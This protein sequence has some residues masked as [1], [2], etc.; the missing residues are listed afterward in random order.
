MKKKIA[1][2]MAA[3]MTFA[4]MATMNVFGAA[5]VNTQ[6]ISSYEED[7]LIVDSQLGLAASIK[8]SGFAQS[9]YGYNE[10]LG[11]GAQGSDLV[12]TM[13]SDDNVTANRVFTV[14]LTGAEFSF[15][16]HTSDLYNPAGTVP[17]VG[18]TYATYKEGAAINQLAPFVGTSF[19]PGS[20]AWGVTP[21]VAAAGLTA[22]A[23]TDLGYI[24]YFVATGAAAAHGAS[25]TQIPYVMVVS[26]DRTEATF[27]Y[28]GG[29]WK[30]TDFFRIPLVMK[31]KTDGEV[32]VKIDSTGNSNVSTATA[33]ISNQGSGTKTTASSVKTGRTQVQLDKI[34]IR[35]NAMGAF[36]ANGIIRLE[37]PEGY[38]YKATNT[39]TLSSDFLAGGTVATPVNVTSAMVTAATLSSGRAWVENAVAAST[40]TRIFT[41]F[42]DPTIL[43]IR[44]G[45]STLSQGRTASIYI[46][47]VELVPYD[48][49]ADWGTELKIAVKN[50]SAGVTEEDVI[51]AKFLDWQMLFTAATPKEFDAGYRD[52]EA[53]KV[54]WEEQSPDSWWETRDVRFTLVDEDGKPLTGIVKFTSVKDLDMSNIEGGKK[55][56]NSIASGSMVITN[57]T[58]KAPTTGKLTFSKEGDYFTVTSMTAVDQWNKNSKLTFI[59]KISTDVNFEGDVYLEAS[60]SG[61][62]EKDL[63]NVRVKIATVTQKVEVVSK[64]TNIKIGYQRYDVA[65][66]EIRELKAAAFDTGKTL[67]LGIAEFSR[68]LI[69]AINFVPITASQVTVAGDMKLRLN[70]VST[71]TDRLTFTVDRKSKTASTIKLTGLQIWT[72]RTVPE[73]TYELVLDGTAIRDNYV[74]PPVATYTDKFDSVGKI[75]LEYIN[76]TTPGTDNWLKNEIRIYS[77][78][79]K[80]LV[81]GKEVTLAAPTVNIDNRMYVPIRFVVE[82][83]G[84]DQEKDVL[85]DPV[86]RTATITLNNK[87]VTW[88]ADSAIYKD[89]T[90][91]HNMAEAGTDGTIVVSKAVIVNDRMYIPYRYLGYAFNIPVSYD[92]ATGA[93]IYNEGVK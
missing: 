71:A 81:N 73:G 65:D 35:E 38:Y 74:I 72:N 69:S 58:A 17:A 93:A 66:I 37:A 26:E 31:T 24:K 84:A 33:T 11:N 7:S 70:T 14:T 8:A 42:D 80:A 47:N 91:E 88:Q 59:P 15:A 63:N 3:I 62:D 61:F 27:Y 83:L 13:T 44:L 78:S 9:E 60:G 67:E 39:N 90:G 89:L 43:Y 6:T 4:S 1:L 45:S 82:Q 32:S 57:T 86:A 53:A 40:A 41:V 10:T 29:V 28:N 18:G 77:G 75:F 21:N 92:A 16:R 36:K 54:T 50:Q 20:I 2:A 12:L 51:V 34:T 85:W 49:D 87:Q 79:D 76:A 25:A 48:E 55:T 52:K 56:T 64:T 68:N 19:V 46:S 30:S 23:A 5:S 22:A